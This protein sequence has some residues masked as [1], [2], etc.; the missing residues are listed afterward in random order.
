[1]KIEIDGSTIS[2]KL[3]HSDEVQVNEIKSQKDIY[4]YTYILIIILAIKGAQ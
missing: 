2:L 4:I 3:V 1:M